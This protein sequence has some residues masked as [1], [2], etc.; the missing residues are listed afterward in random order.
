M[1]DPQRITTLLEE[2]YAIEPGLR[3]QDAA[4][5]T[6]VQELLA[7]K[8]EAALDDRFIERLR[9]E[10]TARAP[11]SSTPFSLMQIFST[12][13]RLFVPGLAMLVVA[14]VGTAV[15]QS[16]KSSGTGTPSR[17]AMAPGVERVSENAFGRLGGGSPVAESDASG[18]VT[19]APTPAPAMGATRPQSGGGSGFAADAKMIAP[20]WIPTL[21]RYVYKGEAIENL[22]AR[23]DVYR[24]VKAA[25]AVGPLAAL[26]QADLGLV[27]LSR[28]K[29]GYVQ[30][31]TVAENRDQGYIF[32]V[33]A[34]E[35]MVNI[36]QNGKWFSPLSRCM[37]QNCYEQNR[38]KES[39]LLSDE[40]SI[41]IADA[42]LAEYGISKADYGAPIVNDQWRVQ[43]A[44]MDAAARSSFW[45]PEGISVVYP[46]LVDGKVAYDE[47]G[48]PY[49]LN[50]NVDVRA[51]RAQS[52][53]NLF[54]R[55]Y[56][57]S[58]YAAETDAKR[59]IGIA[60][61]TDNYGGE[62]PANT[63]Y[64]DVEL[65][66]PRIAYVR[67]W[68]QMGNTGAEILVPALIF[69]VQNGPAELWRQ[70]VIVPLAKD[71][72]DAMPPTVGIPMPVDLPAPAPAVEPT[73]IK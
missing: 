22:D 11:S 42:F 17:L 32:N 53:W 68:Q 35:G 8:P 56:Q 38:L 34:Q 9:A 2:L 73:E 48:A 71:L 37:D 47:S 6:L 30:S 25:P 41:R 63:K 28:A 5:R 26:T 58:S 36:F 51:K 24:R 57:V 54:T 27:D 65:G 50:V 72:L 29:D 12:K 61:N 66:T 70:N 55:T 1:I 60:E 39:D 45:F 20:D 43:Y 3:A 40:E 62:W 16:M 46:V 21:Y 49:G 15:F 18:A 69:P 52:V 7:S 44:A 10:L 59:L 14:V 33:D 31:F 23:I 67:S 64:V 13:H 19:S 4:L